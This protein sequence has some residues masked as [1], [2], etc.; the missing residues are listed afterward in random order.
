MFPRKMLKAFSPLSAEDTSCP[1]RESIWETTSQTTL[2]SSTTRIF[3]PFTVFNFPRDVTQHPNWLFHPGP[4]PNTLL[5]FDATA[6]SLNSAA[7]FRE[8][9]QS[10][11]TTTFLWIDIKQGRGTG[12]SG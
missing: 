3:A 4:N 2:L 8:R 10:V 1:S 9:F 11:S 6:Y 5:L 12:R 7:V